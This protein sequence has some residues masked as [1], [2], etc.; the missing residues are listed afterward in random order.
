MPEQAD[1]LTRSS[2]FTPGF[3]HKSTPPTSTFSPAGT[4]TRP[5]SRFEVRPTPHPR[6]G[7]EGDSEEKYKEEDE[8]L[9]P[10]DILAL[11]T[12]RPSTRSRVE[13]NVV[14]GSRS[15]ADSDDASGSETLPLLRWGKPPGKDQSEGSWEG[16]RKQ[17]TAT[18]NYETITIRNQEPATANDKQPTTSKSNEPP[19]INNKEKRRNNLGRGGGLETTKKVCGFSGND[20]VCVDS[21]TRDQ[22]IGTN[23]KEPI[24]TNDQ[25]PITTNDKEPITTNQQN[26]LKPASSGGSLERT[27]KVCG[28]SGQ[29]WVC[30]DSEE[31]YNLG[32][33]SEEN[34]DEKYNLATKNQRLAPNDKGGGRGVEI[35]GGTES[36]ELDK[37]GLP[38]KERGGINEVASQRESLYSHGGSDGPGVSESTMG[39]GENYEKSESQKVA[40]PFE[41]KGFFNRIGEIDKNGDQEGSLEGG[42]FVPGDDNQHH[43]GASLED[44]H[45][46]PIDQQ[47]SLEA[48]Q[49][50]LEDPQEFYKDQDTAPLI[51]TIPDNSN[52]KHTGA[53][54]EQ[55]PEQTGGEHHLVDGFDV[56]HRT[57][58]GLEVGQLSHTKSDFEVRQSDQ[59]KTGESLQEE[60]GVSSSKETFD[61]EE[62]SIPNDENTNGKNNIFDSTYNTNFLTQVHNSTNFLVN[63]TMV[64][65]TYYEGT[66]MV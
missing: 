11:L 24:R 16:K 10:V 13:E 30:V 14:A 34:S 33:K 53:E 18:N 47:D 7:I 43:L 46:S 2:I 27:G 25:Q 1:S 35:E 4:L 55:R 38:G 20:W 17:P 64:L 40:E 15:E 28:Y 41:E 8:Q 9:I 57:Q 59:I 60:Q 61:P 63:S 22:P 65:Q 12:E 5:R 48:P 37:N 31:K 50:S 44:P 36:K 42:T 29:E 54:R 19:A 6:G 52:E 58:L 39:S 62:S 45:D 23:D 32:S 26:D 21:E 66:S 56:G 49:D 3:S 51:N